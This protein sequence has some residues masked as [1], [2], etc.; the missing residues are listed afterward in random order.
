VADIVAFLGVG[1]GRSPP[2][3]GLT[4]AG[5]Y[6]IADGSVH[7]VPV[8]AAAILPVPETA[9]MRDYPHMT[10]PL[11]IARAAAGLP[12]IGRKG[13]TMGERNDEQIA[14]EV[15]AALTHDP[16]AIAER[17]RTITLSALSAGE[18]DGAA[19]REVM[20]AVVKGAQQGIERPDGARAAA[21]KEAVRGLDEALAA[22]AQATQL[23][24]Q[25]AL[26]R[27]GEFSREGLKATL[28]ELGRLESNFLEVLGDAAKRT[29]GH[30]QVTFRELA[31]HARAS[32]T[33]V[34]GRV[35]AALAELARAAAGLAR[36]QAA[37][38]ARTL[39]NE[40]GLLAGLAA[41]M[42]RGIADRL[43]AVPAQ[44]SEPP[45]PEPPAPDRP[46]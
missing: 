8:P 45:S 10:R 4:G 30:A 15:E 23:A 20:G 3:R 46:A 36:E 39:R 6:G 27:S 17:V 9:K 26:G 32:G 13:E 44:K 34:G 37:G 38:G 31:E 42:L 7:R 41:G 28:D 5:V 19:L 11:P 16:G 21:L 22:A 12:P 14:R 18:L 2:R 29:S 24:V 40:A 43:Q 25:E 35:Q 33:A 1:R